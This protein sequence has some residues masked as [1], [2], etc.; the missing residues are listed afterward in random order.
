M[1]NQ[2]HQK[3]NTDENLRKTWR[4]IEL[5][6]LSSG[7]LVKA[8]SLMYQRSYLHSTLCHQTE[9]KTKTKQFKQGCGEVFRT[10]MFSDFGE[11]F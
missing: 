3:G 5:R 2:P 7:E 8:D 10:P 11:A 4:G 6:G 1:V 9:D